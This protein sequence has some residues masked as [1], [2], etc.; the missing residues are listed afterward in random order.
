MSAFPGLHHI[1]G[2]RLDL[3]TLSDNCCTKWYCELVESA[4]IV[5]FVFCECTP[6]SQVRGLVNFVYDL[7]ARGCVFVSGDSPPGE[8]CLTSDHLCHREQIERLLGQVRSVSVSIL[9]VHGA[10]VFLSH[11]IPNRAR[12]CTA[13]V[14][15]ASCLWLLC[16]LSSLL[17]RRPAI[18]QL[19]SCFCSVFLGAMK[20]YMGPSSDPRL[21][22]PSTK[23]GQMISLQEE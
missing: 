14:G 16:G 4:A 7:V 20:S 17:G 1:A 10:F 13:E 5:F 22:T 12:S 23:S 9:Q 2:L 8:R 21:T 19:S 18:L 6:P 11:C 3:F 15:S